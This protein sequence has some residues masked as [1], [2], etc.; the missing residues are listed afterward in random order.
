MKRTDNPALA[1]QLLDHCMFATLSLAGEDGAPYGVP[2]SPARKG[3]CL[4]FHCAQRGRKVE[5]MRVNPRVS[6]SC[7]GKAEV[8]P[9]KFDIGFQSAVV[10]G[11]AGEVL[12]EEEKVEA[13]RL[14]CEKYCPA[15]MG[16]F[17]RVLDQYLPRTAIW[18]ITMDSITTKG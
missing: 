17:Q 11:T 5:T 15:D 3:R 4:Y 1:E 16:E 12:D 9:G 8:L 7:V 2:I 10:S 14:I 6:L 18:K 13:L